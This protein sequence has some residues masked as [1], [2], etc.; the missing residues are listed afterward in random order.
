MN[1]G[2]AS[3]L[4]M[5]LK[6]KQSSATSNSTAKRLARLVA[7]SQ[8]TREGLGGSFTLFLPVRLWSSL[9]LSQLCRA[10][11]FHVAQ[12]RG[13]KWGQVSTFNNLGRDLA[14]YLG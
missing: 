2:T 13:T 3:R 12:S 1:A 14:L 9:R 11:I 4:R 5:L 7:L 10:R 6:A 8:S